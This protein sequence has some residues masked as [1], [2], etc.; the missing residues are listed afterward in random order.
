MFKS[1]PPFLKILIKA[2]RQITNIR[3]VLQKLGLLRV[4]L[5]V[6][7]RNS[8]FTCPFYEKRLDRTFQRYSLMAFTPSRDLTFT[9]YSKTF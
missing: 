4:S 2:H 5:K 1:P 8:C 7:E 6:V 9:D 3:D